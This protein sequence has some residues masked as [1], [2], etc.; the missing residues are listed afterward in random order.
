VQNVIFA[1]NRAD[2]GGAIFLSRGSGTLNFNVINGTFTGN[3]ATNG[4]AIYSGSATPKI[5][6]T[7]F[8]GNT[9]REDGAAIHSAG[10]RLNVRG[11][12]F[13]ENV[14]RRS[15]GAIYSNNADPSLINNSILW[16]NTA[17]ADG[18]GSGSGA[19]MYNKDVSPLV[20]HT[21]IEGGVNG[22][23][24]AGNTANVDDGGNL[25][26][27][28]QFVNAT[29]PDGPDDTFGTS[30]DRL[31]LVPGSPAIDRGR[32]DDAFA[33]TDVTGAP[34][35]QDDDGDGYAN[36]NLGAY[37]ITGPPR[38]TVA[39]G[40]PSATSD[41]DAS[42]SGAV[43]PNGPE[44]T[45]SFHYRETG[46][47]SFTS[48]TANESPL[49][50][51]SDQS[52]SAS[53]SGLQADT[54]YEVKVAATNISGTT[55]GALKT[56][57]TPPPNLSTTYTR[58]IVGEDGT[59]NDTGWR[60]LAQ[61]A[62]SRTRAALED[63]V[64]FGRASS[65]LYRWNGSNWTAQDQSSDPLPR[66]EGFI[67]YF[68]DDAQSPL[69]S[70]GTAIDVDRGSEDPQADHTVSGLSDGDRFH[71]LGNPYD[72][73]FDLG[74]LAAG[75]LP[76]AGF[77]ATVQVWDPNASR[78]EPI[79]QGASD[80]DLP[81]WQGFFAQRSSVGAGQTSLTF[82]AAGRLS[83]DGA[84]IGSESTSKVLASTETSTAKRESSDE[85]KSSPQTAEVAL[86]LAVTSEGGAPV[87]TD[88]ATYWVDSRAASGY[89][90][91]EA[92][93]LP[94]PTS[95]AYAT[96]TFPIDRSGDLAQRALAA[97]PYPTQTLINQS[98][99]LS[100]R[101][102]GVSGSATI[103]WPDASTGVVPSDW[104][105]RL[106]DTETGSAVD[107]RT[108]DYTFELSEGGSITS[109]SDARFRLVIQDS[110]VPVE[111]AKFDGSATK[112]GGTPAVRL[113]WSTASEE[114]NAGFEVQHQASASEQWR[115]VGFVDGAGTTSRPQSYRF[116]V[117]EKMR[118]GTHRFRL[119]QIDTDGSAHVHD[120]I[121]V[122]VGMNAPVRL[123]APAP[124]PVRHRATLSF[125]VKETQKT[126]VRLYNV[127]GQQVATLY[128]G[129]P[130]AEET[131][132]IDL[133]TADLSS[134][135]YIMRLQA[136]ERTKTRR[137]TVV[138]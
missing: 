17:D 32:N 31:A 25:D 119:K 97:A 61:P 135:I 113:T 16:G 47:S 124:N 22:S 9:A 37:E 93:D 44:A 136:G 54:E 121:S 53:A 60:M 105:V 69:T 2:E 107:L 123:S 24:V 7:L 128:R 103:S 91:F 130:T 66:G 49:T 116:T 126:T 10:G 40:S 55:E 102:L 96:A 134:G 30:D 83:T 75:D 129:T 80:D 57:V 86:K 98:A 23:G 70:S 62:A 76:G 28:P 18:N 118:P 108:S 72:I 46:A 138:K 35:I 87:Y 73:A 39:T 21:L 106:E 14:A 15:G 11:A 33:N 36:V 43:N 52:V 27:D 8:V 81:A 50:G 94:P 74:S 77:Q 111:L 41:S 110:A 34:R 1:G 13:T 85:A 82:A 120:P 64:D 51:T 20:A 125:A 6:S 79:I 133:S 95:S 56:F 100:V 67:L 78:Y 63:D 45:V 5:Q 71:L 114:N 122:E 42:F 137:L 58:R 84:L 59:G 92:R 101:G 89:D 115:D 12:T 88:Q 19:E 127:L 131:Q 68:F 65:I 104:N 3:A 99:P 112:Q 117:D 48:V 109:P 29:D 4:G 26:A 38:P 90:A 132:T